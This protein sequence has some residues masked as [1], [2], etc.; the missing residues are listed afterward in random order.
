[1][2]KS[3]KFRNNVGPISLDIFVL[4]HMI[5]P[6]PYLHQTFFLHLS[7]FCLAYCTHKGRRKE[8]KTAKA[9]NP[10]TVIVSLDDGHKSEGLLTEGYDPFVLYFRSIDVKKLKQRR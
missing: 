10:A 6:L 9:I 4:S 5:A 3:S 7:S 1:M 2:Y 8:R